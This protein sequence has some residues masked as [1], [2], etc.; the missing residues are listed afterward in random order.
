[1]VL[2]ALPL[3]HLL[4]LQLARVLGCRYCCRHLAVMPYRCHQHLRDCLLLLLPL[5]LLLQLPASVRLLHTCM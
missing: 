5:P 1:V 3:L 4:L 2:L